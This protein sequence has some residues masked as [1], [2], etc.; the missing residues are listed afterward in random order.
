MM[1]PANHLEAYELWIPEK[2][3]PISCFHDF[4]QAIFAGTCLEGR[5]TVRIFTGRVIFDSHPL[6]S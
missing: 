3:Y 6:L 1:S 2:D 5:F 4:N